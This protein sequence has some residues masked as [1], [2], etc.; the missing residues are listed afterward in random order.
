M[1]R[2]AWGVIVHRVTKRRTWLKQLS[3]H[4]SVCLSVCLSIYLSIHPS[5]PSSTILALMQKWKN[6][7]WASIWYH[8]VHG[9]TG[10]FIVRRR[11]SLPDLLWQPS[12]CFLSVHKSQLL[13]RLSLKSGALA[14]G[15]LS[16]HRQ[17]C[18]CTSDSNYYYSYYI[19]ILF[20]CS[21]TF[22][23]TVYGKHMAILEA[24]LLTFS[25]NLFYHLEDRSWRGPSWCDCQGG[26][27]NNIL[28]CSEKL[29]I[30]N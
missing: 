17:F 26:F 7:P 16:F 21:F 23:T 20:G 9:E 2:R 8:T 28:L 10:M 1:D 25:E 29:F 13:V 4:T 3:P 30:V 18:V 19:I 22:H 24:S 12:I 14:L 27:T 5:I 15:A 11:A 6:H